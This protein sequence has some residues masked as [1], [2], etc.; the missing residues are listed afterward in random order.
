MARDRLLRKMTA[1]VLPMDMGF[2]RSWGLSLINFIFHHQGNVQQKIRL[3]VFVCKM[4]PKSLGFVTHFGSICVRLYIL[5]FNLWSPSSL[6]CLS[7]LPQPIRFFFVHCFLFLDVLSN[8]SCLFRLFVCVLFFIFQI[9]N[10]RLNS[11][12]FETSKYGNYD[13][14]NNS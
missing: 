9:V 7:C 12:L 4:S 8:N 1:L 3:S 6:P 10:F 11:F 5:F 2:E 13:S 14:S